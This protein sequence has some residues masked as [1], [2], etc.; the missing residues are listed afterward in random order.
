M[1]PAFESNKT[2]ITVFNV[3][4]GASGTAVQVYLEESNLEVIS[5]ER[6]IN[7]YG[8]EIVKTGV[9]KFK[10][11]KKKKGSKISPAIRSPQQ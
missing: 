6:Q 1:E 4:L 11:F 10:C 8:D 9:I 7:K 3:P 2:Q 5:Q